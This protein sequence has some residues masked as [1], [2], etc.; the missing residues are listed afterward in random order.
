M[1]AKPN[2]AKASTSVIK[3]VSAT[4]LTTVSIGQIMQGRPVW[5]P[6]RAATNRGAHM[7]GT[8][9]KVHTR[10]SGRSQRASFGSTDGTAT[11]SS[12]MSL[13]LVQPSRTCI[14]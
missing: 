12:N 6:S 3:I 4:T 10:Y 11:S 8:P 14:R 9:T 5:P 7:R 1:F 2:A 13:T